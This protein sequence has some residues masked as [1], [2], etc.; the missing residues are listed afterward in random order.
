MKKPSRP[1]AAQKPAACRTRPKGKP[2][3]LTG[4]NP[5]IAKGD[6]DAPVREYLAALPGWKKEAC[7]RIDAAIVRTVPGVHKAVRWN[8]PLY[9]IEGRGWFL[10][11]H[12]FTTYLKV[13]FFRGAA[14]KPPPPVA[15]KSGDTRSY[16]VHEDGIFDE[17][18]F[19]AWVKQ[20]AALPGWIP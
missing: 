20:A 9:G 12:A 8:S 17:S 19:M 6:G 10:G 3:L 15:S 1:R 18:Q 11:I 4:G 14:L 7:R 16:H 2:V 13:S 5:Q